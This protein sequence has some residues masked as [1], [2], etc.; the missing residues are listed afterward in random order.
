MSTMID[1]FKADGYSV[2][3]LSAAI[4]VLPNN[5]GLLNEMGLFPDRPVTTRTILI[6]EQNGILALLP[7]AAPGSPATKGKVGK[8]KVRSF[9]VPHIPHGDTVLPS[10]V[11]GV[12]SFGSTT[13]VSGLDAKI[14]EK[15]MTMKAKHD[16]TREWLRM[17]ALKGIILDGDGSTVLY[18]LY[19]QFG[20][21]AKVIDFALDV[22]TTIVKNKCTELKRWIETHLQGEIMQYIRV[23]VSPEFYDALTTHAEVEKAFGQYMALNQ[24]LADDYRS[25]FKFG[26]LEFMEYNASATD[27]AGNSQAF[28]AANEGIA[29]PLG[30]SQTFATFNAPA[31]FNETVNTP[32]L[33]YYAKQQERDFQ[34][35]W[36]LYSES[37][38]LPMCMRP[39][40]LV[41][42]TI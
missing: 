30:T 18:N 21:T 8:R 7:S 1:P 11:N 10:E 25:G 38:P 19:D 4:N 15:L 27:S 3:E 42:V 13:A 37:N 41:K 32:G 33:P 6:E 29:F 39:A 9:V 35:G 14:T 36:D 12:R 23:L 24:N 17:G 20:I 40:V 28:I 5:Y 16:I 22:S 34:Q 26:G 31:E 2:A